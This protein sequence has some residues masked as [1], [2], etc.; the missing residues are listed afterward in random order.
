MNVIREGIRAMEGIAAREEVRAPAER[1]A[2]AR[3]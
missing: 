1:A 3:T 2:E